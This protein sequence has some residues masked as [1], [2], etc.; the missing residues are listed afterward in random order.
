MLIEFI[1]PYSP[2][3]AAACDDITVDACRGWIRHSKIFF[4]R[5][6]GRENGMAIKHNFKTWF[7]CMYQFMRV[8]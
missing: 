3:L 4:P 8:A 5:C 7:S 6:I 2:L 1:P